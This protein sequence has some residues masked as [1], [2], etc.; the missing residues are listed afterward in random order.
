[1]L[2]G[3]INIY[4]ER[5]FT[6]HDVVAKMRGILKQKKIGHTGTLDPDATGVLPVCLGKGTKL[7]D[8]LT[9]TDKTYIAVMKLGVVTDTQD[10][11]GNILKSMSEE[12]VKECVSEDSL[13]QAI[14]SFVGNYNQIPPMYSALKVNGKKLYELARAGI[15][16]ERKARSVKIF[17]I[18]I[19]E[20]DMERARVKFEVECSK[21]TY[22]R[23]LCHDIGEKLGCGAAMESLERTKAA[24]LTKTSAIT[25]SEL[26]RIVNEEKV[27]RILIAIDSMFESYPKAYAKVGF[28]KLLYNG[29]S[30][31]EEGVNL[32]GNTDKKDLKKVENVRMYDD[33][34]DFI[35]IYSYD[36]RYQLFKLEKMFYDAIH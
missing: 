31:P 5:G 2:N 4:K 11:S 24:G 12:E 6:S 3:V 29:N 23:T 34:G 28:E 21:G 20:V 7:C 27:D 15:E 19:L 25:L 26:E 14:E 30:I 22:V 1:M 13:R 36:D 16:V 35:G 8:M 9:D 17:G 32:S 10:M 18:N 33:N